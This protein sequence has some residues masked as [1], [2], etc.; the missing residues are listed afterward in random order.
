MKYFLILLLLC[1]NLNSFGR[2]PITD[3]KKLKEYT[4]YIYYGK[5]M[6]CDESDKSI[7]L[8]EGEYQ[9]LCKFT[10]G[11]TRNLPNLMS[12]SATNDKDYTL[13]SGGDISNTSIEWAKSRDGVYRC[14]FEFTAT[15]IHQG[16]SVRKVYSGIVMEFVKNSKGELL[17]H[18]GK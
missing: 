10:K 2:E 9:L 11:I 6:G 4:S 1:I 18:Y 12:S 3:I 16:N 8:N 5:G 7:C 15:G 13:L 14:F 17:A